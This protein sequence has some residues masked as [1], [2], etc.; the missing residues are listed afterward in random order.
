MK[1]IVIPGLLCVAALLVVVPARNVRASGSLRVASSSAR[2]GIASLKV[3]VARGKCEI[4]RASVSEV[5]CLDVQAGCGAAKT[6]V[7]VIAESEVADYDTVPR[8][9]AVPVQC[10]FGCFAETAES[11]HVTW[12]RGKQLRANYFKRLAEDSQLLS[13]LS[14]PRRSE[15]WNVQPDNGARDFLF[16]GRFFL[17][18]LSPRSRAFACL[19]N[20]VT[21]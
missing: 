6:S 19:A 13:R 18:S 2:S 12:D 14:S 20:I 3:S 15:Q 5:E 10:T 16:P 7:D 17:L 21:T 4:L 11:S 8:H 9:E 1:R